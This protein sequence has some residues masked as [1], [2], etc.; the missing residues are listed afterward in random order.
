MAKKTEAQEGTAALTARFFSTLKGANSHTASPA[1]VEAFKDSL[2]ACVKAGV[3]SECRLKSPIWAACDFALE[4]AKSTMGPAV[5]L[6]WEEQADQTRDE[7]GF[8]S[9]PVLE[10]MMIEH[11][12][13]CW[14][15]LAVAELQ[16]SAVMAHGGSLAQI[17]HHQRKVGAAQQRFTRG[18]ESLARVRKLSR[19]S[20][21]INVAAEGGQQINVA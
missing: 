13:L 7:L 9:A 11:I 1:K 4:S 5:P 8:E 18:I 10:K 3:L 2:R 15:R 14:L 19:S 21:Q 16:F 20:V 12:V 17:E 6:I